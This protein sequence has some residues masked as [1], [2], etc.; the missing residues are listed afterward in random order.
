MFVR[1]STVFATLLQK[2]TA[3]NAARSASFLLASRAL[4]LL[5]S[6][7]SPL[8]ARKRETHSVCHIVPLRNA[9]AYLIARWDNQNFL[10]FSTV[11]TAPL[12]SVIN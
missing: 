5:R 2:L 6:S 1:F 8:V 10:L 3:E 4:P 7:G 9:I 12:C 11:I